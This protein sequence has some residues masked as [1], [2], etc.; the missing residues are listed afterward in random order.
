MKSGCRLWVMSCGMAFVLCAA[1]PDWPQVE[2]YAYPIHDAYTFL[3]GGVPLVPPEAVR[4][5][6][7]LVRNPLDVAISL[8]HHASYSI[9]QVITHM[10]NPIFTSCG[11]H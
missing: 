7:Y 4:G 8:A 2:K 3:P 5:A 9:D 10:A 11:G 6:L 1:E